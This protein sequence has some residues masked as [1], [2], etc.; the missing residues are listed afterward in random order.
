VVLENGLAVDLRVVKDSEF[1]TALNYF[2]GSKAHNIR[3][4]MRAEERG[5]KLNEY[6]LFRGEEVIP[7]ASEEQLYHALELAYIPPELR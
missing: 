1:S 3:L 7:I 4:R 2:S 5:L 6:G